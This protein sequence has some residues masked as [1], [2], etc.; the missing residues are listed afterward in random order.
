MFYAIPDLRT[1]DGTPANAVFGV[2]KMLL[3]LHQNEKPDYVVFAADGPGKTFR[4]DLYEEYKATRDRM[5]DELRIQQEYMFEFLDMLHVPVLVAPGYEADDIIGALATRWKGV[6]DLEVVIASSDKDLFQF[7]GEN[8]AVYDMMKQKWYHHADAVDKFGV[9]P[10][11][12]VDYLSIVGDTSDN[13]PG[14]AGIGP[15]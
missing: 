7:I 10:K 14:V 6:A 13:I 12:V 1:S 8:V 11:Y 15:K 3:S 4:T 9:E 5:P 2:V